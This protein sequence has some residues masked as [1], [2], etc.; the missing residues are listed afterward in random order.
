MAKILDLQL[1]H[2]SFQCKVRVDFLYDWLVWSPLQGTLE[3]LLQH[4]SSRA[5]VLPHSAFFMVQLARAHVKVKVAQ[6]R[7]TLCHP[8]DY[9]VHGILQARIRE[10]VA[11]PFSRG[12]SQSRD[13]IQVSP[14]A[15]R[16][17]TADP[18]ETSKNTAV[19]SLSLL[20][21]IFLIQDSNRGLTHSR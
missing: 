1:Q 6:S 11:F 16:F 2:Q 20:Q 18:P 14:T 15:S 9:T 4:H 5:S 3:S 13:W 7:P 19:S 17:F 12:S 21:W 8:M 10:C